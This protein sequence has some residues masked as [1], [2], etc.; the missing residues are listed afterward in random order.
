[1]TDVNRRTM[2]V[3][4]EKW[5]IIGPE[6]ETIF[7]DGLTELRVIDG[8]VYVSLCQ[9]SVDGDNPGQV[10]VAARLRLAGPT[11]Q[12]LATNIMTAL[13][14]AAEQATENRKKAN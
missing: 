2:A 8:V 7:A 1:M 5:D 13:E 10:K 3:G 11:A 4:P 14:N 12:I 9:H 6:P